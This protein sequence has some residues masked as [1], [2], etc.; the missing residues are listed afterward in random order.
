MPAVAMRRCSPSAPHPWHSRHVAHYT[1]VPE[2][3]GE[4][5]AEGTPNP[6][7]AAPPDDEHHAAAMSFRER[8]ASEEARHG[9]QLLHAVWD[10]ARSGLDQHPDLSTSGAAA[11]STEVVRSAYEQAAAEGADGLRGAEAEAPLQQPPLPAT[12]G[13]IEPKRAC[14][15]RT[16]DN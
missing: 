5:D 13:G 10:M 8:D 15:E 7:V 14:N 3:Q 2:R 12:P 6:S 9:S 4:P 16:D 11:N 1:S